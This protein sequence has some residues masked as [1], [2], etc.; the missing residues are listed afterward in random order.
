MVFSGGARVAALMVGR[1]QR[2]MLSP[3]HFGRIGQGA[4]GEPGRGRIFGVARHEPGLD[5][6]VYLTRSY[7]HSDH[8]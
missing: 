7:A 2:R 4:S 1:T 6:E 5:R 3:S 8:K